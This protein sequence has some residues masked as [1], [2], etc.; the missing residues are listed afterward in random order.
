MPGTSS[1]SMCPAFCATWNF[2][3]GHSSSSFSDC[4]EGMT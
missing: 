2:A 1:G 3:S 4:A